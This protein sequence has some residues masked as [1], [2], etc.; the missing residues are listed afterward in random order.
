MRIDQIPDVVREAT[1]AIEDRRFYKHQGVD[2]EGIVR[3][4]V[5]NLESR[6]ASRAAR[7]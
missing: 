5:K 4:A 2:F 1:V 3:A 6:R 7:R